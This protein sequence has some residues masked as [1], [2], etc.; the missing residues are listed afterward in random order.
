MTCGNGDVVPGAVTT[1]GTVNFTGSCTIGGLTASG[2]VTLGNSATVNGNLTSYAGPIAM[3]GS[4]KVTGTATET[5]GAINLSGSGKIVGM[6]W[7]RGLF[8]SRGE[9][10]SVVPRL[11]MTPP[12]VRR[13]C[14]PR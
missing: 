13:P 14:R 8:P 12:L 11:P 1:Y 4:A 9:P 5:S 6:P 3:S 2:A 7:R 10:P